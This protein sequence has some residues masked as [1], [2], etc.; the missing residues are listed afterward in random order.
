MYTSSVAVPYE[1]FIA[2]HPLSR[3]SGARARKRQRSKPV[4]DGAKAALLEEFRWLTPSDFQTSASR[5]SRRTVPR[6]SVKSIGEIGAVTAEEESEEDS[7]VSHEE[8]TVERKDDLKSDDGSDKE[9]D[10]D[11]ASDLAALRRAWNYEEGD[12][13]SFYTRI[14]GGGWTQ[15]HKGV[16]A[17]GVVG[18]C[19]A[20]ARLWCSHYGWPRSKTYFFNKYSRAGAHM[21]AEEYCRRGEYFF[22]LY[23]AFDESGGEAFQYSEEDVAGYEDNMDFLNWFLE[24]P[25]DSPQFEAGMALRS[26]VPQQA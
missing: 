10:V 11:V 20:S 26:L 15:K 3:T 19:R 4:Q 24:Q 23:V 5:P 12:S 17:D 13:M 25:L 8:E 22:N 21:L 9:D 14:L 18:T 1:D 16:V 7:A 6:P 2:L